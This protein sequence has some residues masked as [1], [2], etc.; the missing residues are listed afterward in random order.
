MSDLRVKRSISDD[1]TIPEEDELLFKMES[2]DI[3]DPERELVVKRVATF[4]DGVVIAVEGYSCIYWSKSTGSLNAAFLGAATM[5]CVSRRLENSEGFSPTL[6]PAVVSICLCPRT[7]QA[8]VA[9]LSQASILTVWNMNTGKRV[10]KR[11]FRN[12][13]SVMILTL[14]YAVVCT[15]SNDSSVLRFVPLNTH[16]ESGITLP[17]D[18]TLENTVVTGLDIHYKRQSSGHV[19]MSTDKGLYWL[20]LSLPPRFIGP[21]P[22]VEQY[23][24]EPQKISIK[25]NMAVFD[26][27]KAVTEYLNNPHDTYETTRHACVDILCDLIKIRKPIRSPSYSVYSDEN[28]A[29]ILEISRCFFIDKNEK[30]ILPLSSAGQDYDFIGAVV[31]ESGL[32]FAATDDFGVLMIDMKSKSSKPDVIFKSLDGINK[33]CAVT[34]TMY[35]KH[36]ITRHY[37]LDGCLLHGFTDSLYLVLAQPC[38]SAKKL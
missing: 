14:Q 11:G 2:L 13:N 17:F 22:C 23:T 19:F 28:S 15:N 10:L 32:C 36:S 7:Q 33:G 6:L 5:T 35:T 4:E 31:T 27:D 29:A 21:V 38:A 12:A 3:D 16:T 1:N 24:D 9:T 18:L 37:S 20:N 25:E 34:E 26:Y 30:Q 8:Y